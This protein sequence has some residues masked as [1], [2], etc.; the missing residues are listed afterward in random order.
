MV[1]LRMLHLLS[2][3]LWVG[4]SAFF[5]FCTALPIIGRMRELATTPGNWVGFT[6]DKQG[7]RIAGEA[8]NVVFARYFPWQVACGV[9]ALLTALAWYSLPG[10]TNKI[11]IGLVSIGL[12]LACLN[13]LVLA[14]KVQEA[15]MQRYDTTHVEKAK[16]A[17]AAFATWHN[18][19]LISDMLTLVCALGALAL[20]AWLPNSESLK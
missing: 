6:E 3:G 11:R 12:G 8:L 7:T 19:S 17:E 9:V 18:Y 2:L 5:S 14:P 4:A 15:R 1:W 10:L 13:L 16:E 20:F